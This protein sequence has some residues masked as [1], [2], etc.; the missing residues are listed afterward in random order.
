MKTQQ[1]CCI[2]AKWGEIMN[3]TVSA[4]RVI[5]TN[6]Q[7]HTVCKLDRAQQ[8]IREYCRSHQ[9]AIKIDSETKEPYA[10]VTESQNE[11]AISHCSAQ[12]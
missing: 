7:L 12:R 3:Y 10:V 9:F 5:R 4:N 11:D 1:Q 8:Q 6:K 2:E